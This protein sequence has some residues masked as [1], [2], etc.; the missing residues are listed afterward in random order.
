[1]S[2]PDP[3]MSALAALSD[4]REAVTQL[5]QQRGAWVAKYVAASDEVRRLTEE[6]ATLA[7]E[8]DSWRARAE[9]GSPAP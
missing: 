9:S 1:V 5:R 8:R 7:T 3:E 4:L 2:A 6:N